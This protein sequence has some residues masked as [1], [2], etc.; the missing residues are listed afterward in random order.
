[1]TLPSTT[2]LLPDGGRV[3]LAPG[4][5][6][7]RMAGAALRLS[8]PRIS[9]AH[10][11]VT[12]RGT[13]LRLLALRGRMSVGGHV[14]G[15]VTLTPGLRI[16]LAGF[17][18]LSVLAVTLPEAVLAVVVTGSDGRRYGPFP[19]DGVSSVLVPAAHTAHLTIVGRFQA[20]AHAV[21]WHHDAS[22][23]LRRKDGT[24]VGLT[25]GT[26]TDLD[27]WRIACVMAPLSTWDAGETAA[28]GRHD[29]PLTVTI[30]YDVV[31]VRGA[32]GAAASFDGL[33]ARLISE[34]ACVGTPVAW[35]G[36]AETLW[37]D[38]SDAAVLRGRWD[39]ATS[40]I[41]RKLRAA[42]LRGDVLRSRAGLVE[43]AL[44]PRDILEDLS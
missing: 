28:D 42:G 29:D 19:V 37:P 31:H 9:E 16:V 4:A 36:I 39:Q 11:L 18:P 20:D 21:L 2:W 32:S 44:G 6:I 25:P 13:D 1:L 7:G 38:E 33:L 30:N 17:F 26:A 23:R 27:G 14:T 8:D 35:E 22:L 15:A 40:R 24:E 12:V 34:V 10:A 41:R 43:V 5:I 3:S